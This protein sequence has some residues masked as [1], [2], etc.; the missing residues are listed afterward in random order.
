[1]GRLLWS[2]SAKASH[3]FSL[4]NKGIT[5]V[6]ALGICSAFF[7]LLITG[8]PQI[9]HAQTCSCAGA[10]L[11]GSQ[12]FGTTESGNLVIGLTHEY[13]DISSLYSGST[14]LDDSNT[15]RLTNSTLLEVNYGITRRISVSATFSYVNKNRVTGRLTQNPDEVTTRGIGD[16][17]LLLKYTL[18]EHSLA[19]QYSLAVGSGFKAPLGT[20]SLRNNGFLMNADMQPGTGAWD[21]VFWSFASASFVPH[22]NFSVYL[23]NSFRLT[24]T[25]ERFGENDEYRFGNEWITMIGTGNSFTDQLGY[26]LS[27]RFRYTTSDR[28]NNQQMPNTGGSWLMINP[29]LTYDLFDQLSFRL[30]GNIP[31]Y[32]HLEGTQPT[33]SYTASLSV[34]YSFNKSA[35]FVKY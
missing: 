10:P 12:S 25:N 18:K 23:L 24:G 20:T 27:F 9:S 28:R 19:S 29:A 5:M 3:L 6:R 11:L 21:A 2:R 30:S 4:T 8:L 7:I 31:I 13:N 33:T 35:D 34:F 15:S 22:T 16:G 26:S 14:F 32:Q 17:I 1:M